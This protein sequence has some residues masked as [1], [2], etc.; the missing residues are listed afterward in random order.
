MPTNFDFQNKQCG[1]AGYSF[2]EILILG[3]FFVFLPTDKK[4]KMEILTPTE[5]VETAPVDICF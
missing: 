5:A 3:Y 2:P 1:V 4:V